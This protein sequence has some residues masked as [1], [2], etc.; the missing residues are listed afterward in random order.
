MSIFVD[1]IPSL[2]DRQL[3]FIRNTTF[4]LACV[5][6]ALFL[7]YSCK[8][9]EHNEVDNESQSVVDASLVTQE[10]FGAAG[11]VAFSVL[12][13]PG[14]SPFT[15][16]A[17]ACDSLHLDSARAP[18]RWYS[19]NLSGNCSWAD[20][21]SRSGAIQL[22]ASV[23]SLKPTGRL[24][25]RFN[26]YR[27]GDLL[28]T[29][30]SMVLTAQELQ[31]AHSS[32]NIQVVNGRQYLNQGQIQ[33]GM[34]GQLH[35]YAAATAPSAQQSSILW[36]T[37]EGKNRNARPFSAS[38]SQPGIKKFRNCSYISEGFMKLTPEGFKSRTINYGAGSC[39][40]LATYTVNE[41]SV[42][43]KLK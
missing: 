24:M 27:V 5:I 42:A 20:G 29:C 12:N 14:L 19:A 10:F 4:P 8:K 9:E 18:Y 15:L 34:T 25:I 36:G 31:S 40:D 13:T 37:L 43:F 33:L 2:V 28:F 26:N 38:I 21:K 39:D 41:N 7:G 17:K 3:N 1:G 22:R 11:S 32:F 23:D 30:D 35:V 16:S 6:A